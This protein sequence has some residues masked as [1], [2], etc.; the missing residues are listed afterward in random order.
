MTYTY[1]LGDNWEHKFAVTGTVPATTSIECI[2]GEGHPVAEDVGHIKGWKGLL[3][4][5]RTTRPGKEQRDLRDWYEH[6]ASNG[7]SRGLA[8]RERVWDQQGV[9]ELLRRLS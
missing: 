7:D 9:C 5:Y 1:D 8:G 2:G 3:D 6:R 4:A